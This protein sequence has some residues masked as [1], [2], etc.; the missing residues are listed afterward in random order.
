MCT[1]RSHRHHAS[2]PL[3]G[4]S[5]GGWDNEQRTDANRHEV[6]HQ[7]RALSPPCACVDVEH[8]RGREKRR[9]DQ[10][11]TKPRSCRK[12]VPRTPSFVLQPTATNL[13]MF[14]VN[15]TVWYVAGSSN[16]FTLSTSASCSCQAVTGKEVR[17]VGVTSV[18]SWAAGSATFE[19]TL[20]H[21]LEPIRCLTPSSKRQ[22]RC[23]SCKH[24][25]VCV[26]RPPLQS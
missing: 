2:R 11:K 23:F 20:D 9:L 7:Q 26:V 24:W 4:R 16:F 18:G 10:R 14:K 17:G 12:P 5:W 21:C 8:Q 3:A 22:P 1:A 15:K 6:S 25:C 19:T 13:V